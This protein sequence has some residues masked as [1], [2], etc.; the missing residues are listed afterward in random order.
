MSFPSDADSDVTGVRELSP[1]YAQP[2]PIGAADPAEQAA[3]ESIE[4]E[5]ATVDPTY[6]FA[7]GH[8][9][10]AIRYARLATALGNFEQGN[11]RAESTVAA[12]WLTSG[13]EIAMYRMGWSLL[14]PRHD[15]TRLNP[16]T[17]YN[18]YHYG[19]PHCREDD[20]PY[21]KYGNVTYADE[22]W[23]ELC[24]WLTG[25]PTFLGK[26]ERRKKELKEK[27]VGKRDDND[28]RNKARRIAPPVGGGSSSSAARPHH[29]N[30]P[31]P[32]PPPRGWWQ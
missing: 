12:G 10:F 16:E 21:Q 31:P 5:D 15:L 27:I 19:Y 30:R 26:I 14:S 32:P 23:K 11:A 22:Q 9:R 8:G 29:R 24:R 17:L 2:V 28:N 18:H 13:L 6:N 3:E 25:D 20:R 7:Q 4:E 1:R